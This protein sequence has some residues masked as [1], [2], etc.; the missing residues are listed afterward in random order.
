MIQFGIG[1]DLDIP[2][3]APFTAD[4]LPNLA[5][6]VRR[7]TLLA[8]QEW[9]EY[10]LGKQLPSGMVIQNRTGEYARSIAIRETGPFSGE[11]FT[12]LRYARAIEEGSPQHDMKRMLDSSFK[13][14]LTK[15]GRRYLIIPFRHDRFNTPDEVLDW[16]KGKDTSRVTGKF[17]RVSGTG[18]YNIQTRK[19]MTVPGW[20]YNW[21]A[22]LGKTD[23]AG[24]GITGQ[25]AKR[26]EGMVKFAN[27]GGRGNPPK[28][29]HSQLVTFRVMVEGS[30]G[31]IAKATPGKYPARTVAE[32]IRPLVE[33]TFRD[34]VTE[35]IKGMLGAS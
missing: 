18:A 12:V 13:V 17:R 24:M 7:M 34:A 35:D 28:G 1:V 29:S 2:D 27:P 3:N 4:A 20:R 30:K 31:W 21:G 26:L 16:W 32:Q 22:R 25:G 19:L 9:T 11:V 15:D 33:Q 14:R 10:A 23:L 5:A 8:H 6:A